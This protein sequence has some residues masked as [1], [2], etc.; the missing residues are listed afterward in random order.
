MINNRVN[1]IAE[2]QKKRYYK[3]QSVK[4]F[5]NELLIMKQEKFK[6]QPGLL[7]P[8]YKDDTANGLTKLIIKYI[9]VR[10]GQAERINSTG[11]PIDNRIT[12][13]DAIGFQRTIGSVKW[14]KGTSTTG[15]ADISATVKGR[16]VKIE[17]KIGKD[18]Q[19][20]AQ[21]QYQKAVETAGGIYYIARDFTSF[22]QWFKNTF[23]V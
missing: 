6:N 5:E 18:Y 15:T 17:V 2:T 10:G 1:N 9:Q 13:T 14:I 12:Y 11:R 16:S 4:D 19:S 20:E 8:T 22:V 21:K 23:A 7:K 3:P